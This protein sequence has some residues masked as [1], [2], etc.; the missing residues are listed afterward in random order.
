MKFRNTQEAV[1]HFSRAVS[2]RSDLRFVAVGGPTAVGKSTLSRQFLEVASQRGI[3]AYVLEGDRFLVP[4]SQ[5]PFPAVFPDDVYELDRLRLAVF[6]IA[7]GEPFVAPFYER[8]GRHTGRLKVNAAAD[9][10]EV[11]AL[12]RSRAS[13]T[14]SELIVQDSGEILEAIQP[15]EGLW[16]LDSELSL[17]YDDFREKYDLSYGIRATR[18]VRKAHFLGAVR[19]GERYPYLTEAEARAK[20]EGFW[21]TDDALIVPTVR[22]ADVQIELTAGQI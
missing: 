8:D 16:I 18:E 12:C 4:Q 5:R 21:E 7:A 10:E 6:S 13:S 9:A 14:K 20:I 3:P 17:L 11:L 1:A 19:N 15:E 22:Y 2:E